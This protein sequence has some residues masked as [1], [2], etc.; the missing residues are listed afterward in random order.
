MKYQ[1]AFRENDIYLRAKKEEM[2]QVDM[3]MCGVETEGIPGI[4]KTN[5]KIWGQKCA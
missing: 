1:R 3:T 5:A 4:R 2:S